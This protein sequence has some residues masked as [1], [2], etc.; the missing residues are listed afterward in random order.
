[1]SELEERAVEV[2]KALDVLYPP[3]IIE[4]GSFPVGVP[5]D[6]SP[7]TINTYDGE[8]P[9]LNRDPY[10]DEEELSI[11]DKFSS[12]LKNVEEIITAANKGNGDGLN[13]QSIHGTRLMMR[14]RSFKL[15]VEQFSKYLAN[16]NIH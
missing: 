10:E 13:G 15:E 16:E 5:I 11:Q 4:A 12:M 14:W 6:F 9:A 2:T 7:G 8:P 1:M 3:I